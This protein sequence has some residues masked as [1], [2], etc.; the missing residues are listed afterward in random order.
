MQN[1]ATIRGQGK[2]YC[3]DFRDQHHLKCILRMLNSS[4]EDECYRSYHTDII[5]KVNIDFGNY[6]GRNFYMTYYAT[7][8]TARATGAATTPYQG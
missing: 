1:K 4:R 2:V 3:Q 5:N 6:E 7:T 8:I